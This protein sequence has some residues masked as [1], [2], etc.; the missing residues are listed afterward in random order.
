MNPMK[1]SLSS[2]SMLLLA[3]PIFL[4]QTQVTYSL[5]NKY[6]V[7]IINGLT[8]E[9]LT[10]HCKSKDD[11][12]RVH[13]LAVDQEFSWEFRINFFDRTLYFCNLVWKGGH[14]TFD[15]FLVDEKALLN[16]CSS[17]DCM[18]RAR[19]DGIYLFNYPHKQFRLKYQW[20]K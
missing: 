1:P 5:F 4:S 9:T 18:W 2:I 11:D 17:S 7:H 13:A 8:N 20:E 16:A 19:D 3:L 10:A 6:R 12:L 15:A 14:K